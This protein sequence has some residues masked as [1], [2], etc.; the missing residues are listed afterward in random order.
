[1]RKEKLQLRREKL[2]LRR[3][4]LQLRREKENIIEYLKNR[5]FSDEEINDMMNKKWWFNYIINVFII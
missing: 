4:K 5:G 1:M 3:E 2:Q